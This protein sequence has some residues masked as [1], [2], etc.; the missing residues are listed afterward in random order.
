MDSVGK[1][2][3]KISFVWSGGWK[4]N[5][6]FISGMYRERSREVYNSIRL[7]VDMLRGF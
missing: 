2:S 5:S 3:V 1:F 7:Y 6:M 4:I